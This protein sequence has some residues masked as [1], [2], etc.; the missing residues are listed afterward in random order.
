M[1]DR[2]LNGHAFLLG[3]N[4]A[5]WAVPSAPVRLTV[6]GLGTY[7]LEPDGFSALSPALPG[8]G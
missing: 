3:A 2:R 1:F 4:A 7:L 8:N 5:L 6:P